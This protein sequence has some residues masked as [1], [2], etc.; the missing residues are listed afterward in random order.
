M[1][2]TSLT[3]SFPHHEHQIHPESGTAAGLEAKQLDEITQQHEELRAR[4]TASEKERF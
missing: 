3:H 4:H 2:G 1:P